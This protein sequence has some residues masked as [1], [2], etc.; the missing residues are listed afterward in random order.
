MVY[1]FEIKIRFFQILDQAVVERYSIFLLVYNSGQEIPCGLLKCLYGATCYTY[2]S[3]H[4][5]IC[6]FKCSS[7]EYPTMGFVCGT[8]RQT[9]ISECNLY[10]DSCHR[11]V[12]I[13]VDHYG[14]CKGRQ[15]WIVELVTGAVVVSV[16][17]RTTQPGHCGIMTPYRSPY[18]TLVLVYP[19]L[20]CLEID[21]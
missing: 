15:L 1:N 11:Q 12:L 2:Y 21:V 9:Y 10:K 17:M 5:C 19:G 18:M 20:V 4:Q 7:S 14:S 13:Q 6:D 8:N 3:I 16:K